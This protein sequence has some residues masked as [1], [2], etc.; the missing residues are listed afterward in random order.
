MNHSYLTPLTSLKKE[1]EEDEIDM[2]QFVDLDLKPDR[3][4]L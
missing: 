4:G 2:G 3:I 1:T